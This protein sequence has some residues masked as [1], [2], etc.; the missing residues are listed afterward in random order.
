MCPGYASAHYNL[1]IVLAEA[2]DVGEAICAYNTAL[3]HCPAY[4]EAHN[5]LGVIYKNLGR[6]PEAV[7]S[8]R[9]CLQINPNIQLASQNLALALSDLGTEAR[10]RTLPPL[11]CGCLLLSAPTYPSQLATP[12]RLPA[13]MLP[14]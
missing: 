3:R 8:Y 9:R 10:R 5:N 2:G 4:P 7:E 11:P 13:A 6:L 1:G 14:P 12:G